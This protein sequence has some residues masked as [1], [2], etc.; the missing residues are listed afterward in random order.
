[1]YTGDNVQPS[2]TGSYVGALRVRT[3]TAGPPAGYGAVHGNHGDDVIKFTGARRGDEM[4]NGADT[5]G[6]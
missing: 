3:L 1:M 6:Q 4:L 5:S 2:P